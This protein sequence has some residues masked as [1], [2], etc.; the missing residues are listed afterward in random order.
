MEIN[1]GF[2]FFLHIFHTEHN[3]HTMKWLGWKMSKTVSRPAPPLKTN[4]N[5]NIGGETN[6]ELPA[7]V[8]FFRNVSRSALNISTGPAHFSDR[9]ASSGQYILYFTGP[10]GPPRY[11][12][13][14][15]ISNS[16]GPNDD[17]S[18]YVLFARAPAP[19]LGS[20]RA[21]LLLHRDASVARVGVGHVNQKNWRRCLDHAARDTSTRTSGTHPGTFLREAHGMVP[22]KQF[23]VW[24]VVCE[25]N[26]RR[27][28]WNTDW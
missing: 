18:H 25:A 22:S 11:M 7:A 26:S 1:R 4:S 28:I 24:V 14:H 12:S 8:R 10:Y 15:Q 19:H 27:L 17:K 9:Q 5:N 6:G 20:F 16:A 21:V 23:C 3:K 13:G 2:W